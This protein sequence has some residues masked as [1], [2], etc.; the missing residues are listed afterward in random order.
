MA[1]DSP[2]S[3]FAPLI[4]EWTGTTRTR[5]MPTDEFEACPVTATMRWV[6]NGTFV[7]YEYDG[8]FNGE[9]AHGAAFFGFDADSG[10]GSIAWVDSFHSSTAPML[11]TGR[12]TPEALLEVTGHYG[13][14]A[15]PWGWRTVVRMDGP[16]ALTILAYNMPPETVCPPYVAIETTLERRA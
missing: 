8:T 14:P 1:P 7:L 9:P 5:F 2:Q 3:R 16:D 15:E 11:S 13:E 12:A 4:G 6:A 10:T